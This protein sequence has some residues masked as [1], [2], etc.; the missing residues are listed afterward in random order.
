MFA[1]LGRPVPEAVKGMQESPWMYSLGAFFFGSQL[2][3]GLLQTGAFEI[4][5]NDQL[6]FSKLESGRMINDYDIKEIF[7]PFGIVAGSIGRPRR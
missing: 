1:A 6:V 5:V 7:E 2:Q 3:A 4:Y